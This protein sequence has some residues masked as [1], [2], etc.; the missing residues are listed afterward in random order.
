MVA[1]LL[2]LDTKIEDGDVGEEEED[3][4]VPYTLWHNTVFLVVLETDNCSSE[5]IRNTS[6]SLKVHSRRS[7]HTTEELLAAMAPG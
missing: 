7:V 4:L 1:V 3:A 5:F 6:C 2:S